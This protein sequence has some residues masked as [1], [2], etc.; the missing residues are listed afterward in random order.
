[1]FNLSPT[2]Q[3][4]IQKG[5]QTLGGQ[6]QMGGQPGQQG[7]M[8]SATPSPAMFKPTGQMVSAQTQPGMLNLGNGG[9]K[10]NPQTGMAT[11]IKPSIM[12]RFKSMVT[13]NLAPQLR[14]MGQMMPPQQ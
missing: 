6:P 9:G 4:L 12:D 5:L 1:M 10:L 3:F 13:N 7:V 8:P 2:Q 11:P 14:Q